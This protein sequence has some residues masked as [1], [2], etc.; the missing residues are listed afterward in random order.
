MVNEYNSYIL[1]LLELLICYIF[2]EEQSTLKY[3][4]IILR[5][6]HLFLKIFVFNPSGHKNLTGI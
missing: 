5:S 6:Q 1:A 3:L 4:F 2:F